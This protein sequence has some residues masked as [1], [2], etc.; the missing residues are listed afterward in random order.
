MK[1]QV[2]LTAGNEAAKETGRFMNLQLK[3]TA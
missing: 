3:L 1:L 2:K